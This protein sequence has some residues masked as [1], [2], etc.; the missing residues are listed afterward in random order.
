MEA[1]TATTGADGMY[2]FDDLASGFYTVTKKM[3]EGMVGDHRAEIY[4]VLV[5]E[6]GKVVSFLAANFGCMEDDSGP[7]GD[8]LGPG[9]ERPQRRRHGRRR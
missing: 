2:T 9:L 8:D 6:D 1:M 3:I 5:A 4:V 7:S